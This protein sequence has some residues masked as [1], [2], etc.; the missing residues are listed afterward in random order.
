[1]VKIKKKNMNYLYWVSSNIGYPFC[2]NK[3]RK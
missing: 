2:Y 1:M 3:A